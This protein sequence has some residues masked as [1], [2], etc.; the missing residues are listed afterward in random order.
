M[1]GS[2][3]GAPFQR[4]NRLMVITGGVLAAFLSALDT[5]ALATVMPTIV[6]DLGGLSLY[7]WV[8]SAYMV[9]A[10][11]AM[12][13]WGKLSDM[14][15]RRGLFVAAVAA[16]LLGSVLCGA[17]QDMVQLVIFRG[18][19]GVGAGGL[20]SIPFALVSTVFP[21]HERGKA[22]GLVSS[23]WGVSSVLGPMIGSALV[24]SLHWRWVFYINLPLGACAVYVV[25]RYFVDRA[26]RRPGSLDVQGAALLAAAIVLT[27]AAILRF[28]RERVLA[29]PAVWTA[30]A[31]AV[32]VTALFLKRERRAEN[33]IL[34]L[35]FF[36]RRP[37]WSG[38]LLG[39]SA[40]FGMY[41]IIAYT[42]LFAQV[43][44]GGTALQAGLIVT[45]MSLSW[46][47]A[48]VVAGRF[49]HRFGNRPLI[50]FGACIMA[51][52][53][54]LAVAAG[55]A[56]PL[57]YLM[58][59][60]AIVGFGM[61]CQTPALML[62][63]QHSLDLADVGVATSTQMLSRTIGG[64]VGVS[65]L[66]ALLWGVVAA[67]LAGVV[68]ADQAVLRPEDLFTPGR[69]DG[70]A[71]EI[72]GRLVNILSSGMRV[73][74]ATGLAVMLVSLSLTHLLPARSTKP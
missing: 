33:P 22:L 24:L 20:S 10:A 27:L 59:C 57:W 39:F 74:F 46:S 61:G 6:A 11:V 45:P 15:G 30:A 70:F 37:F 54:C 16:F 72:H 7:S 8:F 52:G 44:G 19:Q 13:L 60:A 40:S 9:A 35:E 31:L 48:S 55:A 67:G 50:R 38:N 2:G 12:P 36:S 65:V 68:P 29:D 62:T 3:P 21:V 17:A 56:S 23:A 41:A 28:G 64:A 69:L 43:I 26:P 4:K 25:T 49:A 47:T 32:L 66:G 5:T 1:S 71:P 34:H 18:L 51:L 53:F 73:V 42:P 14:Y 58:M 63:V